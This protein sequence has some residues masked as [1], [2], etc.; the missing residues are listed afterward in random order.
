MTIKNQSF[1]KV[2]DD[3]FVIKIAGGDL[4]HGAI[5]VL[6]LPNGAKNVRLKVEFKFLGVSNDS[7]WFGIHL[8][9][10]KPYVSS[11]ELLYV[12]NNGNLESV[13]F[14]GKRKP[15]SGDTKDKP[16][17]KSDDGFSMLELLIEEKTLLA[18]TNERKLKDTLIQAESFGDVVLHAW[19]H[20]MKPEKVSQLKVE[21]R[22]LELVNL[23]TSNPF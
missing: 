20:D 8:R 4:K 23:D 14:P 21:Y 12:R 22:N 5:Q 17:L 1:G 3:S 15:V 7:D 13:T 16:G 6:P 9:A 2:I 11:S 10:Q 18:E 19:A